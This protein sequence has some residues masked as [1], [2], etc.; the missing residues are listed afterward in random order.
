[1]SDQTKHIE[2]ECEFLK[3]KIAQLEKDIQNR[4]TRY[5]Y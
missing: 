1:M 3:E 4:T 2:D 5:V